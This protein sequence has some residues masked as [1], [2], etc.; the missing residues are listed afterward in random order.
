MGRESRA[1]PNFGAATTASPR[2][3]GRRGGARG[4]GLVMVP[5]LPPQPAGPAPQAP[6]ASTRPARSPSTRPA[7]AGL[8]SSRD[9][10]LRAD[11]FSLGDVSTV[12]GRL[13][14]S[15]T[16]RCESLKV[17]DTSI[18]L[19]QQR[20]QLD[21]RPHH[22]T[23]RVRTDHPGAQTGRPYLLSNAPPRRHQRRPDRQ[24]HRQ[25]HPLADKGQQ[26]GRA[27]RAAGHGEIAA[28]N[29]G[30]HAAATARRC[31]AGQATGAANFTG[32]ATAA[33]HLCRRRQLCRVEQHR[34]RRPTATSGSS[35]GSAASRPRGM[36]AL[37][38]R[39]G[40]ATPCRPPTRPPPSSPGSADLVPATYATTAGLSGVSCSMAAFGNHVGATYR[41][42]ATTVPWTEV[43]DRPAF[44][45]LATT[46]VSGRLEQPPTGE[47][48]RPRRLGQPPSLRIWGVDIATMFAPVAL[49]TFASRSG[50]Q[51]Q[52]PWPPHAP[53]SEHSPAGP[54]PFRAMGH[55]GRQARH[56]RAERAGTA[57]R[58]A[59]ATCGCRTGA[60]GDT[61]T[62]TFGGDGDVVE[63][64]NPISAAPPPPS[65]RR[66]RPPRAWPPTR[67]TP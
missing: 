14:R 64:R 27:V 34:C 2:R 1:R 39:R 32:S 33:G 48:R 59:W 38:L 20:D 63:T 57:G 15:L 44:T 60:G 12:D 23:P 16:P 53:S 22:A 37:Q 47:R 61:R 43:A 40:S 56:L 41:R 4:R 5:G 52:R 49:G 55:A 54:S 66:P 46:P 67:C 42:S 28:S 8:P 30:T 51:L 3:R 50:L 7:T 65:L 62:L 21:Q 26:P 11:S 45:D 31:R 6:S 25:R 19:K 18:T 13:T 58:T 17:G 10:R 9:G 24:R 29:A 36:P 35:A